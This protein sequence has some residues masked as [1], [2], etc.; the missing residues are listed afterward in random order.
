MI[1]VLFIFICFICAS[2]S[3]S[4]IRQGQDGIIVYAIRKENNFNFASRGLIH[5]ERGDAYNKAESK[6]REFYQTR[7]YRFETIDSARE[8]FHKLFHDYAQPFNQ[9]ARLK[10]YV[11]NF[12]LTSRDIELE[13]TFTDQT[14]KP[15]TAPAIARINNV[16]GVVFYYT[17]DPQSKHYQLLHQE[18]YP[19]PL[20]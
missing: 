8:F 3:H 15:L 19:N 7:K 16:D 4:L 10:P 12:P 2:C 14:L 1:K 20:H 5:Q 9:D 13:I 11:Q 17:Y 6:I 18:S